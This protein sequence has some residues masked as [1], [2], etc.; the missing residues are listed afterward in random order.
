MNKV[1]IEIDLDDFDLRMY[2]EK[3]GHRYIVA[4]LYDLS[5]SGILVAKEELVTRNIGIYRTDWLHKYDNKWKT[6]T[7]LEFPKAKVNEETEMKE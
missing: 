4:F 5:E 6:V 3:P 2:G 7:S 1:T